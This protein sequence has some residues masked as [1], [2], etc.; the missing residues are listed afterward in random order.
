MANYHEQ[1]D[2]DQSELHDQ[3]LGTRSICPTSASRQRLTSAGA[4]DAHLNVT[5]Y[6]QMNFGVL[7]KR[8]RPS[9]ITNVQVRRR[10]DRPKRE[11]GAIR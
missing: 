8:A 4:D 9:S 1:P 10:V 7:T 11:S 2:G 6:R 5:P 3:P